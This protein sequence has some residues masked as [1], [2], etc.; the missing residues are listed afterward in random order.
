M[1]K[2]AMMMVGFVLFVAAVLCVSAYAAD[3]GA[4]NSA[5]TDFWNGVGGFFYNA[6]PWNWGNWA[7]K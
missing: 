1:H 5:W 6:L 3:G 7:G 2:K 4:G